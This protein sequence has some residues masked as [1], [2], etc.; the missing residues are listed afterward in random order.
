LEKEERGLPP[1]AYRNGKPIP[2]QRAAIEGRRIIILREKCFLS[3]EAKATFFFSALVLEK[4]KKG[5]T[6][7]KNNGWKDKK[8]TN[9]DRFFW[10]NRALWVGDSPRLD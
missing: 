6:V 8:L 10:R 7:T 2:K 9:F 4:E 5:E 1:K 3:A